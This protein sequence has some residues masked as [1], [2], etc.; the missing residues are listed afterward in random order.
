M[1]LDQ[2]M[3]NYR[4]IYATSLAIC[5]VLRQSRSAE[6][7][8][9]DIENVGCR[10]F[11]TLNFADNIPEEGEVGLFPYRIDISHVQRTLPPRPRYDGIRERHH[12]PLELHFLLIPRANTAQLQQLI[13]GWM[14]RVI[15]DNTSVPAN[16]LNSGSEDTFAPDEH[17]EVTPSLLTTEE[18]LRLWD[19][20]PSDFNLCVPYCAKL[21]RIASPV[22]TADGV[23]VLQR[24]LDFRERG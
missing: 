7:F 10:V 17:I 3:A 5:S 4:A 8:G 18:I 12:L 1:P 20:L 19:Q 14:M 22:T 15:E 16:I 9:T 24:D 2:I 11:S 13:L 6:L 23:P 21:L